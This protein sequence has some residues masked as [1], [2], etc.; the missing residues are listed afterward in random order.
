VPI[1]G[2][3]GSSNLTLEKVICRVNAN[4]IWIVTEKRPKMPTRKTQR[5]SH[6]KSILGLLCVLWLI[7]IV[8]ILQT[9]YCL[10]DSSDFPTADLRDKIP[11]RSI[12]ELAALA[13]AAM[14]F[15]S[16]NFVNA[17]INTKQTYE[18]NVISLTDAECQSTLEVYLTEN[19]AV[20]LANSTFL[21][22]EDVTDLKALLNGQPL[23]SSV[24]ERNGKEYYVLAGFN[25]TQKDEIETLRLSFRITREPFPANNTRIPWLFNENY[26]KF[27]SFPIPSIPVETNKESNIDTLRVVFSAPFRTILINQ[28]GWGDAFVPPRYEWVLRNQKYYT[29][30][31]EYPI[32][33]NATEEANTYTFTTYFSQDNIANKVMIVV[34]PKSEIPILLLLLLASPFYVTLLE[35]FMKKVRMHKTKYNRVKDT[36]S[37]IFQVYSFPLITF[38]VALLGENLNLTMLAF[39]L[40]I[41]NPLVLSFVLMYPL[42]YAIPFF[43]FRKRI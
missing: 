14:N 35:P 20:E 30:M 5:S 29:T 18:I 27:V 25:L 43:Y 36:V 10:L 24:F 19:A 23:G 42:L 13:S 32:S 39:L 26:A 33:Q 37:N 40:E 3:F 12:P 17:P 28:S 9:S 6:K 38:I 16:A 34:V 31:F 41:I 7:S 8:L 22:F 4:I 21:G 15:S 11:V 1:E 2:R